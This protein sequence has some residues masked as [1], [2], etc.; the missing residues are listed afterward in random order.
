MNRKYIAEGTLNLFTGSPAVFRPS[1]VYLG[2]ELSK[3]LV[4]TNIYLICARS[5]ISIDPHSL[6]LDDKYVRGFFKAY[7]KDL[8]ESEPFRFE[9]TLSEVAHPDYLNDTAIEVFTKNEHGKELVIRYMDGRTLT[10]SSVTLVCK[11]KNN[12]DEEFTKLEVLYVGKAFGKT[13]GRVSVDRLKQHSTLQR[14]MSE[15]LD[16]RPNEE[17]IL[18][19]YQYGDHKFHL[20]SSDHIGA[21][22]YTTEKEGIKYINDVM[23]MKIPRE[24]RILIAEA[25]LINYFRPKYNEQHSSSFYPENMKKLKTVRG[26]IEADLSGLCVEITTENIGAKLWT[27]RRPQSDME[28][29]L[30]TINKDYSHKSTSSS[31]AED[32]IRMTTHTHIAKFALY[33][34][35]ERESFLSGLPW[36]KVKVK[37]NA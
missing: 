37:E 3:G 18:L 17:I 34:E 21:D 2:D 12:L 25:A 15:F 28:E 7:C 4:G 35:E 8:N 11:S 6:S 22:P 20:S 29:M 14:I 31:E 16:Y 24:Q 32:F 5:K 19:G 26:I 27:S 36:S 9:L 10:I 1:D 30:R 23:K 33:S 13:G